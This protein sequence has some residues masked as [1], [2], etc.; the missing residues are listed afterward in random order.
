MVVLALALALV[1]LLQRDGDI[2]IDVS[3]NKAI[4]DMIQRYRLVDQDAV[5]LE[6]IEPGARVSR[7]TDDP[8]PPNQGMV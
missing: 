1:L 5:P 2:A 4:V 3:P 6:T 8:T 7:R